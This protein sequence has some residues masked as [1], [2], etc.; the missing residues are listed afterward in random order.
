MAEPGFHRLVQTGRVVEE[1]SLLIRGVKATAAQWPRIL[2]IWHVTP[3]IRQKA[4]TAVR[5]SNGCG[6]LEGRDDFHLTATWRASQQTMRKAAG[7]PIKKS[8]SNQGKRRRRPKLR[9]LSSRG[10]LRGLKV[11]ILCFPWT[12]TIMPYFPIPDPPWIIPIFAGQEKL[13]IKNYYAF[14]VPE[15]HHPSLL[16]TLSPL[17]SN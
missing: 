5:E 8:C 9:C 3:D 14:L 2:L 16:A 1:W 12:P 15:P 4:A 6:L 7:R 11:Y 17:Y 10:Q 13:R